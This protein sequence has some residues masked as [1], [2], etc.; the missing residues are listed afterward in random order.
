MLR[1]KV[2]LDTCV[3]NALE[4]HG[5]VASP[6]MRKLAWEFEVLVSFANL[7]EIISTTSTGERLALVNRFER[8]R[9]SG[10]CLVPPTEL[11]ELMVLS[12]A[13]APR[14]FEWRAV[15]VWLSAA[16]EEMIAKREYLGDEFCEQHKAEMREFENRFTQALKSARP[17]LDGIPSEERPEYKEL[18]EGDHNNGRFI[19]NLIAGI[20]R[21]VSGSQLSD[22]EVD[23][24]LDACPPLRALALG[25]LK[26]F[27]VWSLR[28]HQGIKG[29]PAGRADLAMAA[30]L[31]YCHWFVTNDFGQREGVIRGGSCR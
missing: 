9:R 21:T 14:G 20:Y 4:D 24:L 18:V 6:L 25:Q 22:A 12:H 31:P 5:A 8:L 11:T 16:S 1:P 2:I 28:G 13:G 15:D 30:Y 17:A 10:K 3:I 7:E 23:G 19:C 27:H 29:K 26:G